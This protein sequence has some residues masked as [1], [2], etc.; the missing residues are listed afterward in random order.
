MILLVVVVSLAVFIFI[1]WNVRRIK[2]KRIYSQIKQ[3]IVNI[4]HPSID[5][6]ELGSK[7]AYQ[8]LKALDQE[9]DTT[10]I[11]LPEDIEEDGKR[12]FICVISCDPNTEKTTFTLVVGGILKTPKGYPHFTLASGFQNFPDLNGSCQAEMVDGGGALYSKT[13]NDTL[14]LSFRE[15]SEPSG[16]YYHTLFVLQANQNGWVEIAI[17]NALGRENIVCEFE[18]RVGE[19]LEGGR[20]T[21]IQRIRF[22][23]EK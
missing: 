10:R 23:A 9:P 21:T 2:H 20:E 7:A 12:K 5:F 3:P 8:L 6:E 13:E 15:Y 1:A 11:V 19:L 16:Q 14:F 22:I 4:P 18:N 17:K